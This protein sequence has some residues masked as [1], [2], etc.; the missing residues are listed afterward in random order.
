GADFQ[1]LN[2]AETH[3]WE[4]DILADDII[5]IHVAA[6]PSIDVVVSLIDPN[7]DAVIDQQNNTPA[8][9]VET[10]ANQTLTMEDIYT[11]Q[12]KTENGEGGEY[13]VAFYTD[14]DYPT[15]FKNIL[16]DGDT[17]STHLKESDDFHFFYGNKGDSITVIADPDSTTTDLK[18]F[19]LSP[20]D[21]LT[22]SPEDRGK[23]AE[24]GATETLTFT[25]PDNGLY[26]IQIY[27]VYF[28]EGDYTISLIEN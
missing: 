26:S 1:L 14:Y 13:A 11:L 24:K 2:S 8:G 19:I 12:I 3:I 23:D 28:L 5:T 17:I 10:I 22:E 6:Q 21:I 16:E 15:V 9:E 7:G 4:L 27:E 20:D 25:L 18:L